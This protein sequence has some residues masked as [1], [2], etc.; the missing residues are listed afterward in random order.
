[1]RNTAL[2]RAFAFIAA[3]SC[4]AGLSAAGLFQAENVV[5]RYGAPTSLVLHEPVVGIYR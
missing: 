4:V 1:M 5:V 3:Y 2:C